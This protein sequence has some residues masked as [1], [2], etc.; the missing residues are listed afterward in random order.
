MVAVHQETLSKVQ[1]GP[2][3][4]KDSTE[5][6]NYD[7]DLL[8]KFSLSSLAQGL[9]ITST[10]QGRFVYWPGM[11]PPLLTQDNKSHLVTHLDI[12]S[13]QEGTNSQDSS[14]TMLSATTMLLLTYYPK[15]VQHAWKS[16]QT[17]LS[18]NFANHP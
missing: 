11:K 4:I 15:W 2:E 17:F 8:K 18:M 5:D 12:L 1:F 13:Y 10:L 14:S 7:L 16:Q 6:C 9:V 3:S